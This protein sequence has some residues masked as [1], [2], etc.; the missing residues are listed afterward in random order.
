[1]T[2]RRST[3]ALLLIIALLL[4]VI[5]LQLGSRPF[6]GEAVA[7]A[8]TAVTRVA[9]C[10]MRYPGADCDY[11][12]LRVDAEGLLLVSPAVAKPAGGGSTP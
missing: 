3:N 11:R 12:L 7:Q 1:M 8:P 5:A 9:G 4:G 10:Y 6:I 2:S